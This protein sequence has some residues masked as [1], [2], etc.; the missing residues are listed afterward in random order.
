[1]TLM[2]IGAL[3]DPLVYVQSMLSFSVQLGV[4]HVP[5]FYGLD[6]TF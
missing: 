4:L 5:E 3:H 1:M 2:L 6:H